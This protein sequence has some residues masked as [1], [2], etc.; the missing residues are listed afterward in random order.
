MGMTKKEFDKMRFAARDAA[1]DVWD[2]ER[3]AHIESQTFHGDV[4]KEAASTAI[5][6]AGK[7]MIDMGATPEM[8]DTMRDTANKDFIEANDYA[9]GSSTLT[10][11]NYVIM[12]LAEMAP[13]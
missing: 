9:G 13:D 1:Q 5:E 10:P 2:K 7:V 4:L 12:T 8:V 11:A 3:A 6:A